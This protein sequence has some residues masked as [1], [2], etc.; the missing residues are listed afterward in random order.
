MFRLFDKS[1]VDPMRPIFEPATSIYDA[2]CMAA[3]KRCTFKN[4]EWIAYEREAVLE[5]AK[6]LAV[7]LNLRV[8]LL[9]E[10]ERAEINAVGSA[11]YGAKWARGVAGAM[12]RLT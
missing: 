1:I 12:T 10:V 3:K 8:P 9:E 7:E 11:D 6:R 5:T 2:F 4:D